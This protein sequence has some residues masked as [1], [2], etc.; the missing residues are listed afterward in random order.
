MISGIEKS[1]ARPGTDEARRA[2]YQDIRWRQTGRHCETTE[3]LEGDLGVSSYQL[4]A[5]SRLQA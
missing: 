5:L 2:G 1:L 4:F 3:Y